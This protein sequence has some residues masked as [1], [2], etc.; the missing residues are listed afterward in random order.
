[1]VANPNSATYA[2]MYTENNLSFDS[3]LRYPYSNQPNAI[4]SNANALSG[5][6]YSGVVVGTLHTVIYKRHS[7]P[8]GYY[9]IDVNVLDDIGYL[10]INGTGV[11]NF[12]ACCQTHL[13]VWR[14]YLDSSST[15]E[16]EYVN[17]A[18]GSAAKLTFTTLPN[19][20]L[21][22]D[23]TNKQ[24][25]KYEEPKEVIVFENPISKGNDLIIFANEVKSISIMDLQG[26]EHYTTNVDSDKII[27]N[28]GNLNAGI[29]III[30]KYSNN[31]ISKTLI[32]Q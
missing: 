7:F 9:Q 6:A 8:A 17:Y 3:R 14:G 4:P 25:E 24:I 11:W 30:F 18:S 22:F 10:N 20:G 31:I 16:F 23:P 15:V 12:Q 28:T 21:L 13:N 2:G 19:I 26:A 5:N 29:Y 32:I 1:M 27:I